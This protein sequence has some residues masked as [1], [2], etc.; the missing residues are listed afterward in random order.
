MK[1]RGWII[2]GIGLLWLGGVWPAA[3]KRL[4][5]QVKEY[6]EQ[7]EARR[8]EE[9]RQ[10]RQ[11]RRA[12]PH[13]RLRPYLTLEEMY[14]EVDRLAAERPGVVSVEEM[15]RSREGRPIKVARVSTGAGGKAE[16][17]FLG[18]I[19]AQELAGGMICLALLRYVVEGI[20]SNCYIDNLLSRADIYIAPVQN[21]DEMARVSRRQARLGLA[22]FVRKNAGGVDLNRNFPYPAEAPVRLK[23]SAGSHRRYSSTYRGPEPLSEPES[24]GL[25]AFVDRHHFVAALSFHTSGGMILYPPGT[26]PEPTPDEALFRRMAEGYRKLQFDPYRVQPE[27]D[28]YPTIGALDDYLYHRYGILALTVE[29]GKRGQLL[30]RPTI[31]WLYNVYELDREIANNLLPALSIV[32][33]AIQVHEEPELLQWRPASERWVGEPE[34]GQSLVGGK[35]AAPSSEGRGPKAGG[36]SNGILT[37][38]SEGT[39]GA[40]QT[41]PAI[42]RKPSTICSRPGSGPSPAAE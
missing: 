34:R 30:H 13:R 32:E 36:N 38:P 6:L 29:V 20:G 5:P 28:L 37:A 9:R 23:A 39:G 7:V 26:F 17:L 22:G 33:W 41:D 8:E 24:R 19:H 42:K 10:E 1:R 27:I 35:P 14:A 11:A 2:F 18:N 31:F 21:P 12:D 40:E 16:V 4:D 15:G 3:A 25:V